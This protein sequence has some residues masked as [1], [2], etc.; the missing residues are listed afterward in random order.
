MDGLEKLH[1]KFFPVP[2]EYKGKQ[3]DIKN[4]ARKQ[5]PYLTK[6][7]MLDVYGKAGDALHSGNL[8]AV[9]RER[10]I[11][12]NFDQIQDWTQSIVHLLA[13]HF[14]FSRGGRSGMIC[15]LKDPGGLC[16]VSIST[17]RPDR[18]DPSRRLTA[19]VSG[20]WSGL[21]APRPS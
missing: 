2:A 21:A 12:M 10:T 3:G 13:V 16:A 8:R 7:Q 1:P 9:A 19:A 17:Q 14:I 18:C 11:K 15:Q 20:P 6:D 4:F 5:E